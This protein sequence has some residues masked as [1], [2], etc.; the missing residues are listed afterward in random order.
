[1]SVIRLDGMEIP[2]NKVLNLSESLH[3]IVG[4]VLRDKYGWLAKIRG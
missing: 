1:M 4:Y 2:P 3:P